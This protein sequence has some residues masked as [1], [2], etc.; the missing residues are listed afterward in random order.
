VSSTILDLALGPFAVRLRA[1]D[2]RWLAALAP[3]YA[4]FRS[5]A[6][7]RFEL[8]L[9]ARERG[10]VDRAGLLAMMTEAPTV[11]A[12][13]ERLAM[14]S[15][16]FAI[17]LDFARGGR[18]IGPCHRYPVDLALRTLLVAALDDGVVLHGAFLAA[19]QR[20]FVCAGPSGAGKSTLA[21]LVAPHALCDELT[22]VRRGAFGGWRAQALP[23]WQGR[24]GEAELVRLVLLDHAPRH[25]W[26][27]VEPAAAW[28]RLAREVLWPGFSPLR[29]ASAFALF[30]RLLGEV[31]IAELGFRP[32]PD[33]WSVL[34]SAEQAA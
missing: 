1:H 30:E 24:P 15:R 25:A 32:T 6:A 12:H 34:A 26:R 28:R 20:G 9:V 13:G 19:G 2:P 22:L 3:R 5:T 18:V 21:T 7:P 17:E 31:P 16:S 10:S 11:A 33:V 14:R 8:E 29:M 23:Y 4:G 27:A